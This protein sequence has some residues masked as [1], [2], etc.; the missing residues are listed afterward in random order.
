[1]HI[2]AFFACALVLP[3][4]GCRDPNIGQSSAN[5]A[6]VAD[7]QVVLVRSG[8]EVGAFV[9][10]NQQFG[11]E[12]TDY[13]WFLRTDGGGSFKNGDAAVKTGYVAKATKINFGNFTVGWSGHSNQSGWVYFSK[14]P[15]DLK[16]QA[17][18]EMC[19]TTATNVYAV[20][21]SDSRWRYRERP[22]IKLK[23]L[24]KAQVDRDP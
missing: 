18:F 8:N 10:K 11:P 17:A 5:E 20:D 23:E 16:K 14:G 19:V 12:V 13:L 24:Y 21:A 9:L 6:P 7:G 4:L 22:S 15:A 3:V 2:R 1:M